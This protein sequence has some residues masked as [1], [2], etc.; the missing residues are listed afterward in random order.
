MKLKIEGNIKPYFVQTLC[1]LY[2]PGEG[3]SEQG[4]GAGEPELFLSL[5]DNGDGVTCSVTVMAEGRTEKFCHTEPYREG[6][7][8]ERTVKTAA[9]RAVNGACGAVF[10]YSP[11]WGTLTG[12]R[13]SKLAL[14]LLRSGADDCEIIK[15]LNSEYLVSETKAALAASVARTE[16]KIIDSLPH[17]SCSVYISIPFCPSRCS[18]CSFVSY[19]TPRLLSMIPDYLTRLYCDIDRLFDTIKQSGLHVVSVYIGG[20]TPTVLTAGQLS[21][22]LG[23]I[24]KNLR[25]INLRE[26][27]LEAGRPD[28]VTAEKLDAARSW[29]VTRISVNPQTLDDRVLLAIGRN[30]TCDDFFRAYDIARKSCIKYINTD[31]IAGLPGDTP[32]SFAKSVDKIIALVPENIT[33]HTFCVKKSADIKISGVSPYSRIGD[34]VQK[35]VD[36]SQQKTKEAGYIPYY[37]YRQKNAAGNLENVGFSRPS[38]EGIYNIVIMEEVHSIFAAG[39]GAVTKL[40]RDGDVKIERLFMPKYPYEYIRMDTDRDV[41]PFFNKMYDFFNK[42]KTE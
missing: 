2:F 29:G 3:F 38:C 22:L 32:E 11:S 20:G 10:G 7:S 25:N 34:G 39:A 21:G 18:Y 15:S 35:S 28:T 8:N 4:T 37:M 14:K 23:Q 31:L 6:Y 27:T 42:E 26:Y 36:Y 24:D 17:R 40:V 19:S 1:M 16:A 5:T 30:H 13:P 41:I 9:G 33:V 12:V